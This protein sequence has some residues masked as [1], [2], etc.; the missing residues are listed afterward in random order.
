M[1]LFFFKVVCSFQNAMKE[2]CDG[3]SEQISNINNRTQHRKAVKN[4]LESADTVRKQV[5]L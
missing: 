1:K 2:P 5:T 4:A 3:S